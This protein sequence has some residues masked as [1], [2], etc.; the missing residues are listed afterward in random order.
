M[1]AAFSVK[2]RALALL[3]AA[4]C[5]AAAGAGVPAVVDIPSRAGAVTFAHAPHAQIG[6]TDCHHTGVEQ[7]CRAC[8]TATST[9]A[10]TGREAFHASCIGCH[11]KDLKAGAKTGPAKRCSA[12]HVQ[13]Q[14]PSP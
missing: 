8:H 11:L 14:R 2:R 12:C 10:R 7:G 1:S 13:P 9:A 3:A 6:C 4:W 5:A